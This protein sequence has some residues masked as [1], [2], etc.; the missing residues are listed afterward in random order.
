MQL[1]VF[2]IV[3]LFYHYYSIFDLLE[4]HNS[5]EK[6]GAADDLGHTFDIIFIAIVISKSVSIYIFRKNPF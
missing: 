1:T 6:F 5:I 3:T 2:L 4:D